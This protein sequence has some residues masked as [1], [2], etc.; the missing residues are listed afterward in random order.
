MAD[1]YIIRGDQA[2][3][4]EFQQRPN[5]VYRIGSALSDNPNVIVINDDS[6][7][8][9]YAIQI[10]DAY[11]RWVSEFNVDFLEHGF[12]K[13]NL[14]LFYLTDLSCKR[15]ELFDTYN[16][17]C[18]L[19]VIKQKLQGQE[20]GKASLIGL[21]WPF[22]V[23]FR[24]MFPGTQIIT[25]NE[26]ETAISRWKHFILDIRYLSEIVS[27]GVINAL[28]LGKRE[29][30][31]KKPRRYFFS[32]YPQN[33][34]PEESAREDIKYRDFVGPEDRYAVSIVMD[35]FHQH[36]GLWM[37]LRLR[38]YLRKDRYRLI[39]NYLNVADAGYGLFWLTMGIRFFSRNK[40]RRYVFDGIDLTGYI[41]Q[42]LV[43][44]FSRIT[45]LMIMERSLRRFFSNFR[46][47]DFV[48][49]LH[50]YPIG[51]LVSYVLGTNSGNVS[52]VG[53]Q[54][55]PASWRKMLYFMADNET[56]I[57]PPY[58]HN[59]PIP[60]T[61]L[62][63][64]QSSAQIYAF[65]GYKDVRVMNKIYRLDYLNELIAKKDPR[66]AAI[67]PGLHDGRA[68]F[69]V[70]NNIIEGS[71][72]FTYYFRPHP[73]ANNS[74]ISAYRDH[75]NL[76]ITSCPIEQLLQRVSKVYVTYSSVGI[77]AKRVGLDVE[78]INIPGKIN[79]SPLIEERYNV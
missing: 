43:V 30:L 15:T 23:A 65:S 32:I 53:F 64:D 63:E 19:L 27:V 5:F 77:E 46:I 36:V 58:L 55:G 31:D 73:R 34:S 79:E 16:T 54:H 59:A 39:D 38:K 24:S 72:E 48:Y 4:V 75:D 49:Y 25:F 47:S 68:L 37:Y 66:S 61:V 40:N 29:R 8:H 70:M 6:L 56:S 11:V 17:I 26:R 42:E 14:S 28:E 50:E 3:D 69:S 62:A 57:N 33:L 60:D 22:R 7:L 18:N 9:D 51:R 67:V 13:D 35:G 21:D 74:Y 52:R 44:S 76:M 2:Y 1:L 10:R 45:R 12:K 78:I 71:P 41:R 20:I